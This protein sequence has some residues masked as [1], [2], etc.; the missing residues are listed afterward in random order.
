MSQRNSQSRTT[1]SPRNALALNAETPPSKR[2]RTLAAQM[3]K[4]L[5][6]LLDRA[7]DFDDQ[8]QLNF[9][10][11]VENNSVIDLTQELGEDDDID[12][13]LFNAIKEKKKEKRSFAH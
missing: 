1:G 7:E 5:D 12:A 11:T 10:N 8:Q 3:T 6:T 2:K 4:S 9:Q 13:P